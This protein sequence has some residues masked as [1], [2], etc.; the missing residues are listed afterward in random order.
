MRSLCSGN[1]MKPSLDILIFTTQLTRKLGAMGSVLLSLNYMATASILRA[2]TPAFGRLAAVE[3]RL[4]GEYRTGVGRIGRESEEIAYV[5]PGSPAPTMFSSL[6]L[7]SPWTASIVVV[8]GKSIFYGVLTS[9]WSNTS[10]Q[11]TRYVLGTE[12]NQKPMLR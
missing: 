3:A 10:T 9:G 4:E 11:F 1:V 2:V 8:A 6:T 7:V 12:A 5:N